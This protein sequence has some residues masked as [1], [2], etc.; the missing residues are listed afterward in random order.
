MKHRETKVLAYVSKVCLAVAVLAATGCSPGILRGTPEPTATPTQAPTAVPTHHCDAPT[1]TPYADA[2]PELDISLLNDEPCRAP[3]WHNITPGV[4]DEEDVRAQLKSSPFVKEGT[5]G[6][7]PTLI[8]EVPVNVF[9]WKAR[10]RFYNRITLSE[11]KVL[12]IDIWIDHDWTLGDVVDKFGP[13]EGVYDGLDCHHGCLYYVRF[14]YPTQGVWL[15]S[16]TDCYG[17][18]GRITRD[19]RVSVVQ[20]FEPTTLEGLCSEAHLVPPEYTEDCL[21]EIVEWRGF[22]S[23]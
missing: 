23:Y 7:G 5:L 9:H 15:E 20:Y 1:R 10:D 11:E 17:G 4:S 19:L 12:W 3:C 2:S 16:I 21:S 8:G 14:H 13:P 18:E 22:F 6:Y